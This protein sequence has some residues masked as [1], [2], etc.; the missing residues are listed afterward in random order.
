MFLC[1]LHVH[2]SED[3][4]RPILPPPPTPA[5]P[6][7]VKGTGTH[8]MKA[9]RTKSSFRGDCPLLFCVL[10]SVWSL[11]RPHLGKHGE[12]RAHTRQQSRVPTRSWPEPRLKGKPV[13]EDKEVSEYSNTGVKPWL[14]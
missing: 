7:Q 2:G 14:A 9:Q 12:V 13:L 10:M 6:D 5:A 4:N 8:E 11:L 3:V 1:P